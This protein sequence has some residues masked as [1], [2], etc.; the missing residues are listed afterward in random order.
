MKTKNTDTELEV[1]E[2]SSLTGSNTDSSVLRRALSLLDELNTSTT[3]SVVFKQIERILK[4]G[5][6]EHAKRESVLLT[7]VKNFLTTYLKHLTPGSS[8]HLQVKLIQKQ[9]QQPISSMEIQSLR[10]FIDMYLL[11]MARMEV[12]DEQIIRDALLP[13][14]DY[15]GAENKEQFNHSDLFALVESEP[16]IIDKKNPLEDLIDELLPNY[17][18]NTDK[19][20]PNKK[21]QG[22]Y[23]NYLSEQSS[24]SDYVRSELTSRINETVAKHE[25]F[26]VMLEVIRNGLKEANT[27][28]DIEILR[29][30][31]ADDVDGLIEAHKV[32]LLNLD[33]AKKYFHMIEMDSR[34]LSNE[35]ARVRQ[36]SITDELT[37]LPNRRAFMRRLDDELGRAQRYNFNLALAMVDL[38]YFKQV[39][40]KY[41]HPVGDQ[42]LKCYADKLFTIFRQHDLVCRYGGEE[43]AVLFPNT[44]EQG[45]LA[46]IEKVRDKAKQSFIENGHIQVKVPSF[47]AGLTLFEVNDTAATMIQRA[48]EALYNAKSCGR[49]RTEVIYKSKEDSKQS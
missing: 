15:Y 38:D 43:F 44:S 40:D 33:D 23:E 9:L 3:G 8:L 25:Q 22:E 14:L 47:S 2:S 48:D 37:G 13:L 18:V 19:D 41:G 26:G 36:L 29:E 10:K 31:L 12:L 21:I 39:N 20:N 6:A 32:L 28:N 1:S 27:V 30:A 16:V 4:E 49:D 34:H 5:E 7:M 42:V 17:K 24:K 45:A 46:A 35:L 11:H